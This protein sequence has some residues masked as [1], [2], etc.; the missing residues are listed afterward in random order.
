MFLSLAERATAS[1]AVSARG[2]IAV[3][4]AAGNATDCG[5]DVAS[6]WAGSYTISLSDPAGLTADLPDLV[7]DG[8]AER[9]NLG[10]SVIYDG[11]T[12]LGTW[13]A[14]NNFTWTNLGTPPTS[15]NIHFDRASGRQTQRF[16][17]RIW[18]AASDQPTQ[19]NA[20]GLVAPAAVGDIVGWAGSYACVQIA[21]DGS[22]GVSYPDLTIGSDGTCQFGGDALV[23]VSYQG[24]AAQLTWIGIVGGAFQNSSG[25]VFF[26]VGDGATASAGFAGIFWDN[27]AARPTAN[28]IAG[29][30]RPASA[31]TEG[32]PQSE[33]RGMNIADL[34]MY[35][36][37]GVGG[38]FGAYY[39]A[40]SARSS[41]E[42]NRLAGEANAHHQAVADHADAAA[43]HNLEHPVPDGAPAQRAAAEEFSVRWHD[44]INADIEEQVRIQQEKIED[45][46]ALQNAIRSLERQ[47]AEEEDQKQHADAAEQARLDKEIADQRTQEDQA[48]A[49]R[50]V[51]FHEQEEADRHLDEERNTTWTWNV[52][53]DAAHGER[54]PA[55]PPPRW[56]KSSQ[57]L[58]SCR[59]TVPPISLLAMCR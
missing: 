40:R 39:A 21:D 47:I 37:A 50:E 48:E 55:W 11:T 9:I 41:E 10:D 1:A 26:Q 43:N 56:R 14:N 22:R 20:V 19:P 29:T 52:S 15:G 33:Q 54:H 57:L 31:T 38:L 51:T 45:E 23:G 46:Q 12:S 59:N 4:S 42:A 53:P 58:P 3:F 8:V 13:T 30:L 28:N 35:F 24:A 7:V 25:A 49:E 27:G 32:L 36:F 17:G 16:T 2:K 18:A 44:Q 6:S 5:I 34:V